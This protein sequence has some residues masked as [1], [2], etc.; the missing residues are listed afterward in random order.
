MPSPQTKFKK[1]K[2]DNKP[3]IQAITETP[4]E[5]DIPEEAYYND[6]DTAQV[7]VLDNE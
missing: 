3:R 4:E 5:K 6:I 7:A 2:F 1:V